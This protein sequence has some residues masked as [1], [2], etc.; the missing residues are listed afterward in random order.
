VGRVMSHTD[1][2]KLQSLDAIVHFLHGGT[3]YEVI[4][5]SPWWI[6]SLL[7]VVGAFVKRKA[8]A[9]PSTSH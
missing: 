7:L 3:A 5:D 4:G 6:V 8:T 2:F 1:T 9:E